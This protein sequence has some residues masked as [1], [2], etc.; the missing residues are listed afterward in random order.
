MPLHLAIAH[1]RLLLERVQRLEV[2]V[3]IRRII[4]ENDH[5]NRLSFGYE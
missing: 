3:D 5:W 4:D 2:K 1:V